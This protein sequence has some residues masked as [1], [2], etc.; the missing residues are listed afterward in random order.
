MAYEWLDNGSSSPY[1]VTEDVRK[2]TM[3]LYRA[4]R[5]REKAEQERIGRVYMS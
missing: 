2:H 5:A 4:Q 3:A 1:T